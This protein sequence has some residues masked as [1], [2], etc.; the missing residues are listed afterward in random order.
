M[1]LIE[2]IARRHK[3]VHGPPVNPELLSEHI[4]ALS[5]SQLSKWPAFQTLLRRLTVQHADHCDL[6]RC[7]FFLEAW[8]RLGKP[9]YRVLNALWRRVMWHVE[10]GMEMDIDDDDSTMQIIR[11]SR[12]LTHK[13]HSPFRVFTRCL[14][15]LSK[16]PHDYGCP[17]VA[18]LHTCGTWLR[19]QIPLATDPIALSTLL[20][21]LARM[22]KLP[23]SFDLSAILQ[24]FLQ[25][26]FLWEPQ[27]VANVLYSMGKLCRRQHVDHTT[28]RDSIDWQVFGQHMNVHIPS[29]NEHALTN[30]IWALATMRIH[31]IHDMGLAMAAYGKRLNSVLGECAP[32]GLASTLWALSRLQL[33]PVADL[34]I[35]LMAYGRAVN[36]TVNRCPSRD[37][38]ILLWAI[39][40][41]Q[42]DPVED[43]GIDVKGVGGAMGSKLHHDAMCI[44]SLANSLGAM[45]HLRLH[46]VLDLGLDLAVLGAA[47]NKKLVGGGTI[48][49]DHGGDLREGGMDQPHHG[50]QRGGPLSCSERDIHILLNALAR[51]N[52]NL[53]TD[54]H[55]DMHAFGRAINTV[56]P[57][58][59]AGNLCDL[60]PLL[61]DWGVD[62][63]SCH[64]RNSCV[65]NSTST[66]W[67][68]QQQ[69]QG[70]VVQQEQHAAQHSD[71]PPPLPRHA[72]MHPTT[73][74]IDIQAYGTALNAALPNCSAHGLIRVLWAMARLHIHPVNHAGLDMHAYGHALNSNINYANVHHLATLLLAITS[75]GLDVQ[76][77]V[78]LTDMLA[79]GRAI[80]VRLPGSSVH[81][82]MTLT[83]ALSDMDATV[84]LRHMGV[85]VE[86]VRGLLCV[87]APKLDG[88][89]LSNVLWA[90]RGDGEDGRKMRHALFRG[91]PVQGYVCDV[92]CVC[93]GGVYDG[94]V[95]IGVYDDEGMTAMG[96]ISNQCVL[97]ACMVHPKKQHTHP[98]HTHHTGYYTPLCS[99]CKTPASLETPPTPTTSP[100][101][102]MH[103]PPCITAHQYKIATHWYQ[104]SW[105]CRMHSVLCTLWMC[106]GRVLCYDALLHGVICRCWCMMRWWGVAGWGQDSTVGVC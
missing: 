19:P 11:K 105:G 66:G 39:S 93:D 13:H 94:G 53:T 43:M 90:M 1:S 73:L 36:A 7:C 99:V 58:M 21:A 40:R 23:R 60:L 4:H 33:D 52:L 28:V 61:A 24:R 48:G 65:R 26:H 29:F 78:G 95:V 98:Y 15:A 82:T 86:G 57:T 31:P 62:I 45:A 102:C 92:G 2:D 97:Q 37:L 96:T 75:L 69:Q 47:V 85:D 70:F 38:V 9:G 32:Q 84:V 30:M 44:K 77:D 50:Q 46:P 103:A 76:H 83:L 3:V 22:N 55:L 68:Q 6:M 5:Y 34:G 51:L 63:M 12:A 54:L 71:I 64:A 72:P 104:P 18:D 89:G 27:S 101:P 80:N 67:W 56:L 25:L 100:T 79:L 41:L 59:Q 49:V 35:D 106:C 10:D 91:A 88:R 14:S 16:V 42:L 74:P 20:V 17:P 87:H 8:A 81:D